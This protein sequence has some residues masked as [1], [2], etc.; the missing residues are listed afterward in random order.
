MYNPFN[1]P[2]HISGG[3]IFLYSDRWRALTGD[4]SIYD[5]VVG[6]VISFDQFPIQHEVPRSLVLSCN[7]QQASDLAMME[8]IKC[9]IL[10]E[11]NS[12]IGDQGFYSTIFPVIKTDCSARVILNL[13]E[14]NKYVTFAHFKMETI[15][16]VFQLISPRCYDNRFQTCL[17]LCTC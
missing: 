12:T 17:F 13:K 8:F 11:C 2:E 9:G 15:R 7:N 6:N 5:I 3:K 16:D 4:N 1:T 10:E 14:L